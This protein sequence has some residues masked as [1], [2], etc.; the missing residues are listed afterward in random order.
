MLDN[1]TKLGS[2][3]TWPKILQESIHHPVCIWRGKGGVHQL[4]RI[5]S[6]ALRCRESQAAVQV[7][8]V[9]IG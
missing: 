8:L 1:W 9:Q 3:P 4:G 6:L 2:R 5:L 7:G